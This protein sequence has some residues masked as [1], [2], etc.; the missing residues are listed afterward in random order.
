MMKII[1]KYNSIKEIEIG[2][3]NDTQQQ[4]NTHPKK[5]QSYRL[6]SGA[7]DQWIMLHG[8]FI[9]IMIWMILNYTTEMYTWKQEGN[10]NSV[11][12]SNTPA[13]PHQLLVCMSLRK[14]LFWLLIL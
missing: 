8:T 14:S 11:K 1:M 5:K 6:W 10:T 12:S 4:N 9:H 7:A 2:A 3:H 13:W